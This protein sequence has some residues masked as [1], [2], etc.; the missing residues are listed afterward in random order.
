MF[1]LLGYRHP[2]PTTVARTVRILHTLLALI[3]KHL[4]CD[5]F[6]VNTQSVAYLAGMYTLGPFITPLWGYRGTSDRVHTTGFIQTRFCWF[7]FFCEQP[8]WR[9]LKRC[10]AAAAWSTGSP[11][12]SRGCRWTRSPWKPSQATWR[13]PAAGTSTNPSPPKQGEL[14]T[15]PQHMSGLPL[16]GNYHWPVNIN[17]ER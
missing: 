16:A 11:C 13:S 12:C 17:L 10:G 6:E 8:C 7:C 3:S 14:C 5:K 1:Y 2:S 9:S 15:T 4:K